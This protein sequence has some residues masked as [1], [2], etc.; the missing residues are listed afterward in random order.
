MELSYLY[1]RNP[2]QGKMVSLYWNG[3]QVLMY[4]AHAQ[5]SLT[6]LSLIN[7][8]NDDS[9][10]HYTP[11]QWSWREGILD[12]PYPSVRLSVRLSVDDMVSGA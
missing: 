3:S 10:F 8:A 4:C 5:C 12:S 9:Y 2:Y 7:Y 6:M 11:A 1:D